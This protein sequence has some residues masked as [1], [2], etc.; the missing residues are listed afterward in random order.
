MI[1]CR[2]CG[3]GEG[4]RIHVIREMMYGTRESFK[5]LECAECGVNQLINVPD[6]LHKYYGEDYYSF[7]QLE[8][9]DKDKVK[10]YLKRFRTSNIIGNGSWAG[11]LLSILFPNPN[12]NMFRNLDLKL[13]SKILDI[14]CGRGSR[15]LQ[16]HEEGFRDLTGI[17]PFIKED[18]RYND[19]L[20]VLRGNFEDLHEQYDLITLHHVFEHLADPQGALTILRNL[21]S[22]KGHIILRMPL[23]G[24]YAWRKYGINW[25]QLDAPRH[26]FIHSIKSI[27]LLT[28]KA[29]INVKNVI[30][31]STEFQFTGSE[32]YI[33]DL[34]LQ[35]RKKNEEL[36]SKSI[37]SEQQIKKYIEMANWLNRIGDGDSACFY[38]TK[39][40]SS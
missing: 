24:C 35:D 38:L 36:L 30:F 7:R 33:R 14:G 32:M 12:L 13:D 40:T 20:Q 19:K 8:R 2:I 10:L 27:H 34:P 37:L 1:S 6:S 21:L 4:N 23:M 29:G 5:Y 28:S 16:L 18:I 31:D 26:I 22:Q 39:G 15:L 3:N 17:D 11:V 9:R 25:I